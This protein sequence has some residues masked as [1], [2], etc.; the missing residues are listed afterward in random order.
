MYV[1]ISYRAGASKATTLETIFSNS[2]G[3]VTDCQRES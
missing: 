3:G 2:A 1:K